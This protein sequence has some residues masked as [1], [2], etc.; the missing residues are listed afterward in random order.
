MN[1]FRRISILTIPQRRSW[2]KSLNLLWI[3]LPNGLGMLVGAITIHQ[4]PEGVQVKKA[5]RERMSARS[6]E[7]PSNSIRVSIMMS[8]Q[9]PFVMGDRKTGNLWRMTQMVLLKVASKVQGTEN[10]MHMKVPSRG[11]EGENVNPINSLWR[12]KSKVREQ[13]WGA[14]VR[15]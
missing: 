12:Q 14:R 5:L 10:W 9:M 2:Q 8:M 11:P 7:L 15:R 1:L 3:R 13:V 6:L 4:R